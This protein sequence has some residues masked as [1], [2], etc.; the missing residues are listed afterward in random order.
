M[1]K[2]VPL[3]LAIALLATP[4][5]GGPAPVQVSLDLDE[6]RAAV[7]LIEALAAGR[8]PDEAE[9]RRLLESR[10]YRRLKERE[11]AMKRDFT[12]ADFRTFLSAPETVAR[13]VPLRAAL[14]RWQ[15][16]PSGAAAKK[17]LAYL[18]PGT[19][20]RATI[21]P[22]VKPKPNEFAFDL[23][24]EPAIFLMVN[25]AV[26]REKA[27]NT[28]AHELHHIGM[29]AACRTN[30]QGA[31]PKRALLL[32]WLS[33]YG[34]GL[35]MLAAAGGPKIHPHA[36]SDRAERAEWD[37]NAARFAAELAEQDAWFR[38]ILAG[39]AGDETAIAAKMRGYFGTQGA[40]YTVG[41]RMAQTIEVN[42][43]RAR[44]IAAFCKPA[45]LLA[46][47][48]QAAALQEKRDGTRLP[49]WDAALAAGLAG[50][51]QR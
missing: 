10:G 22:M 35:A 32:G 44:T 17:A 34:E 46:I 48:N 1:S 2:P 51:T 14:D 23:A 45:S 41:W 20:L 24:G 18:P 37:R 42:L 13:A 38:S 30:P 15:A 33:A 4:T 16:D 29:G 43:G 31:E 21:F 40:W 3:W 28:L 9:W 8:T 25:P 12:D 27:A 47:Y 49:R 36:V 6:A 19:V 5:A 26:R 7:A 39:N 11:A 50:P